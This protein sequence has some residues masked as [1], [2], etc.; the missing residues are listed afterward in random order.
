M[1]AWRGCRLDDHDVVVVEGG[2]YFVGL[3][4]FEEGEF[5]GWVYGGVGHFAGSTFSSLVIQY[6][7]YSPSH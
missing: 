1:G 4:V 5:L 2:D 3:V 7:L 6:A